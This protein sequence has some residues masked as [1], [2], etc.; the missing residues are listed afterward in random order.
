M[1]KDKNMNEING[2]RLPQPASFDAKRANVSGTDSKIDTELAQLRSLSDHRAT[3]I[4]MRE[5]VGAKSDA[6]RHISNLVEQIKNYGRETD[7]DA[8]ER[9]RG[10][11][12]QSI[13]KLSHQ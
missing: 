1:A 2:N 13:E 12:N 6:G 9:L 10:F 4:A 11:I 8:R 5:R 7:E 3:L